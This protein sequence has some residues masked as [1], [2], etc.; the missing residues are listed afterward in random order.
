MLF[1]PQRAQ[2]V[3]LH[4]LPDTIRAMLFL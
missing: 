4:H 1:F 3:R 2:D